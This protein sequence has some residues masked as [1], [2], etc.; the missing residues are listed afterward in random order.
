M[1]ACAQEF[2]VTEK[3]MTGK[4]RRENMVLPRHVAMYLVRSLTSLSLPQIGWR[5]GKR[6]HTSVLH[7]IVRIPERCIL[8]PALID[9]IERIEI[10]LLTMDEL[11]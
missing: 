3:Q 7:A 11:A 9:R 6:D 10:G 1:A 8:D 4:S 2:G 5:F